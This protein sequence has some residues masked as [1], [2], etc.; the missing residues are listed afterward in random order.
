[1]TSKV[2]WRPYL[3]LI[4]LIAII[5]SFTAS[6]FTGYQTKKLAEKNAAI[7]ECQTEYNTVLN[8]RT[9]VLADATE[10]ERKAERA[11]DDAMAAYVSALVRFTPN[12]ISEAERVELVSLFTDFSDSLVVQQRERAEADAQ[13]EQHPIPAPPKENCR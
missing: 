8:I 5:L 1:M 7:L 3:D 9:R 6:A 10:Q 13:R 11:T 12:G 2:N 4:A